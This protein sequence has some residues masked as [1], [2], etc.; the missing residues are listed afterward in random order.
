MR[1]FLLLLTII[2]VFSFYGQSSTCNGSRYI[3]IQYLPDTTLDILY[4]NNYTFAGTNQDLYLDFFEPSGDVATERPLIILAFGGS[5]VGG[6]KEDLHDICAYYS[7]KGYT[8]ATIDYRLYDGPFFPLPDSVDITDVVIKAVGDM[9]AAIRFFKEDAAN[10][11]LYKIDT[12]L[13][14]VGGISAG[15][16]V[17]DHVGLLQDYNTIQPYIQTILNNNGGW[18]GNSS[19]NTQH[20]D[21]VAGVINFSGALKWASYVD[22]NDPPIFS[23]HDDQDG[24]VPYGTGQASIASVPLIK[25]QGSYEIDLAANA[26][27]SYSELITIPNSTG[28]VSYF[29][30]QVGTDSI[31]R[32]SCEFLLPIVCGADVGINDLSDEVRMTIYPNP[33]D[34]YVNFSFETVQPHT[35]EVFDISGKLI[36]NGILRNQEEMIN[37]EAFPNGSYFFQFYDDDNVLIQSKKVTINHN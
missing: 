18:T 34:S 4:G 22:A 20:T 9:K 12:N 28:H 24:T 36:L 25:M 14:F 29:S 1:N 8:A 32:R 16:I 5:F 19:T 37:V 15:A 33:A 35:F 13:I 6:A 11:N 30:T 31:L 26:V 10:A 17:A 21:N 23:V 7:S 2:S 3:D 27:G